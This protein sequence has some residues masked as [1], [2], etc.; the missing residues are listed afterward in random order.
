MLLVA[1]LSGFVLAAAAPWLQR[2]T[3][4]ATGWVLAALPAALFVFFAAAAGQVTGGQAS[5]ERYAWVPAMGADLSLRLDGLSL[6]FALLITGIGA[7]VLVY[8]GGYLRG[9]PH[10]GRLYAFLLMFMASMIGLVLSDNLL[11]LFVFWELTTV[12]SYLLIG[13]KHRYEKARKAALQGML[14][15]GLGGLAMLAGFVLLASVGGSFEISALQ[16][17][18]VQAHPL[19]GAILALVLLGAFTKS[20]QFPFHFWL[21]GA[22]EAP[23]PVSAYLH[24]A[25]M[26]KAGVFLLAR[27]SPV[28]GGT[29]AWSTALTVAGLT[30]LVVGY[31]LAV[32]QFDLKRILAY[33]TVAALGSLVLL[34][35]IGGADAIKAA[36]AFLLAHALYKGALFMAAG[37]VD[38]EAGTR[39]I[40]QLGGLARAMPLTA[41]ATILSALSMAGVPLLFGFVAKELLY[42]AALVQPPLITLVVLANVLGVVAA[43]LVTWRVFFGA[44]GHP[45]KHPHEAPLAMW[46]GPALL[47]ALSLAVGTLPW[48][49]D[50]LVGAAATAVAGEPQKVGLV[51]WPGIEGANGV[52]LALSALTLALGAALYPLHRRA[53]GLVARV[54]GALRFGPERA[55]TAALDGTVALARWQTRVLQTGRLSAYLTLMLVTAVTL[56]G[57]T[58]LLRVP[59]ALPP[60]SDVRVYE[61]AL[62]ALMVV[63]TF[64]MVRASSRMAAVL[65][66][67][68][69]GYS[70]ALV[71]LL[72][73]GPDLAMTQFAV[74][75][76]SVVL[77]ALVIY[78][79]PR[80]RL[81]SRP[82]DRARGGVLAAA[83]GALFTL[84]PLAALASPA[85][86]RLTPYFAESS[87]AL[88]N[89]LNVVNVILVDFRGFDTLGEI[90]VLGVAAIG[91]YALMAMRPAD[92]PAARPVGPPEACAPAE[93]SR[94]LILSAALRLLLPLLL[95]FSVFLLIRGHN[96]PGGGFAGGLVAAATFVLYALSEGVARARRSLLL[97]ERTF[98]P[99]GLTIALASALLSLFAGQ[100]FMTGL[101]L[102]TALP[103]VG[104]VGTPVIFDVG[105]YFLV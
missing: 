42:K 85:S 24:S 48:L 34:L 61:V 52:A 3:R 37:T 102:P 59:L 95:V 13:Y 51:L 21:P 64:V 74:E 30:T 6:L 58:L 16:A 23:S 12:S 35:G 15:T 9:D 89:G 90:T 71:F 40:R 87:L 19:Y 47:T 57:S 69:V 18:A 99:I 73:G 68:V 43:A 17:G 81:I 100:P 86:S 97:S 77:F 101:W 76:L 62:A 79:L 60:L 75:T 10:I 98:I 7:L 56:A 53:E 72:Y 80:Y 78:R 63:A 103:V 46:L 55:Y 1:V 54:G 29:A 41:G 96:M 50:G 11:A 84:I 88:A 83:A 66:L 4:D 2:V 44:A 36:M 93:G 39:D 94:S 104:K 5:A 92:L 27:L 8:A 26:V 28:L 91:I 65:A 32:V 49:A 25:T 22:M 38:H 82:A 33:T 14:V 31:G 105:V 45:P 70:M 20:A 67:G